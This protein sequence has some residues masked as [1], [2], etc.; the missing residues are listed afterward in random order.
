M[1]F[2]M[3]N[4]DMIVDDIRQSAGVVTMTGSAARD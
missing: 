1:V 3:R 4:Y 2:I